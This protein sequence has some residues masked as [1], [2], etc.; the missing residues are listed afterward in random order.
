MC[1]AWWFDIRRLWTDYHARF[2]IGFDP[3]YTGWDGIPSFTRF[4][5]ED[6]R[7]WQFEVCG[8]V[9]IYLSSITCL[10]GSPS[11]ESGSISRSLLS[12]KKELGIFLTLKLPRHISGPPWSWPLGVHHNTARCLGFFI[13]E[14]CCFSETEQM[15]QTG[16]W[17]GESINS[18]T[19][20]NMSLT[21]ACWRDVPNCCSAV[22]LGSCERFGLMLYSLHFLHSL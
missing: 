5:T 6:S 1:A 7:S 3:L 14:M 10:P 11:Q 2:L 16:C 12:E 20:G 8:Q 18:L 9:L 4:P 15:R 17:Q 13:C 22:F 19:P 21:V